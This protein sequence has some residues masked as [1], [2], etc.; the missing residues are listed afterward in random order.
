MFPQLMHL[1]S[2]VQ[3]IPALKHS[4]YFFWQWVLRQLQPFNPED[5][6]AYFTFTISWASF[7]ESLCY[8]QFEQFLQMHYSVHILPEAKHS[9]Y[10]LRHLVF[11][12]VQPP[13]FF[14]IVEVEVMLFCWRCCS[15]ESSGSE[16]G[17]NCWEGWGW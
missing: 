10:I 17:S 7:I 8:W 4:Q 16:G 9:Q 2:L 5:F 15:R 1:Q 6:V 14:L 12:Q 11:L 3:D 13:F